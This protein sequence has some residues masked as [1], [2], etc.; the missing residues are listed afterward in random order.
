MYSQSAIK[1]TCIVHSLWQ[2]CNRTRQSA[3]RGKDLMRSISVV[4][5]ILSYKECV[6]FELNQVEKYNMIKCNMIELKTCYVP[7]ICK[8]AK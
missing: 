4:T 5:D 8:I 3:L 1:K 6:V 2:S 7:L